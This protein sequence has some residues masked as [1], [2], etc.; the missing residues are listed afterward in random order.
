MERAQ[1][2]SSSRSGSRA[3]L[4]TAVTAIVS[5]TAL[6]TSMEDFDGIPFRPIRRNV[7]IDKLDDFPPF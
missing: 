3:V 7:A 1:R 6:K 4:G 2:I 5:P